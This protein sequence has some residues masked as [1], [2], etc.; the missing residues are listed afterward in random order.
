MNIGIIPRVRNIKKTIEYSLDKKLI[1]ILKKIYKKPK[2]IILHEEKKIKLNLLIVSGGNDISLFS[3]KTEDLV[4]QKISLFHIKKCLKKKIPIIG[5][6]YGAQL[7]AKIFRSKLKKY[8]NHVGNH[9]IELEKEKFNINIK[10]KIFVNSFHNYSITKLG[11]SLLPLAKAKDSTVEAFIHRK[12]KIL[13]VM[14]HPERYSEI[15]KIDA[16]YFSKIK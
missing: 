10:K 11:R 1:Y 5:I 8:P 7:I 3:N 15:K 9:S 4:R 14:W 6:C 2:I 13:G 12:H 16:Q